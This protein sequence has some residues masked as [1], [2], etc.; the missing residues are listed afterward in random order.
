LTLIT[1]QTIRDVNM[2]HFVDEYYSV[3]KFKNAYNPLIEPL[4]DKSRWPKIDISSFIGA[5]LGKRSVDHT[6]YL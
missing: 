4:P 6:G 1:T 3:K 2:E 5:P